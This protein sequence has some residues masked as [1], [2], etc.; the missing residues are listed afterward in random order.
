MATASAI[1]LIIFI[2]T[3]VI[4][5]YPLPKNLFRMCKDFVNDRPLEG[6][7]KISLVAYALEYGCPPPT[8]K[9]YFSDLSSF[10]LSVFL[11]AV[12]VY[13]CL[14]L[15]LLIHSVVVYF[16]FTAVGLIAL[17]IATYALLLGIRENKRKQ[18]I[19]NK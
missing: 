10:V 7:P 1:T 15:A 14:M 17:G 5:W 13:F 9:H 11:S 8:S 2:T 12:A 3:Q 16:T 18:K 4:L 6:W 19:K